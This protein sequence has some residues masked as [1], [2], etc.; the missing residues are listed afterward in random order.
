[1]RRIKADAVRERYLEASQQG[2][3]VSQLNVGNLDR[4]ARLLVGVALVA[5][6]AGGFIGPWGY[7]G[8]IPLLTG[9]VGMCP[10]YSLLGLKTTSR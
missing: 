5:L 3:I 10:L 1:M 2:A 7:I 6:A 9:I 4:S 8:L